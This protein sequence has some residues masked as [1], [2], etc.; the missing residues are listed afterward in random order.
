[1]KREQGPGGFGSGRLTTNFKGSGIYIWMLL[2][3]ILLETAISLYPTLYTFFMSL[4]NATLRSNNFEFVGLSNYLRAIGDSFF[5]QSFVLTLIYMAAAIVL[6]LIAGIGLALLL[7]KRAVSATVARGSILVPWIMGEVVVAAIWLW[8][9]DH[10]TGLL[11]ALLQVAHIP[12][13]AWL[14]YPTLAIASVVWVA[15]WRNLAFSFFIQFAAIQS[16]PPDLY[17]AARVDGASYLSSLRY[18]TIPLIKVPILISFLNGELGY[19]A[20]LSGLI[21]LGNLALCL[22]YLAVLRISK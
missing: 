18:I 2:P 1:L 5:R 15:L 11:N 16:I 10:Q 8:I 7:N 22:I 14:A 9:L 20:A 4:T 17:E 6:R 3:V 13:Q 19:G 12:P 21:L